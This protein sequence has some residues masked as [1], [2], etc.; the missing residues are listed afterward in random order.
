MGILAS[1]VSMVFLICH[2]F[3]VTRSEMIYLNHFD[4]NLLWCERQVI[5]NKMFSIRKMF[6]LCLI[7]SQIILKST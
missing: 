5:Y 7:V 6:G 4:L 2:K 3:P 1:L